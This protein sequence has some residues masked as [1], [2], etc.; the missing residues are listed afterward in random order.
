MTPDTVLE[1]H[2]ASVNIQIPL[3]EHNKYKSLNSLITCLLLL[4]KLNFKAF[5]YEMVLEKH[6]QNWRETEFFL[7]RLG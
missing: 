1:F 6:L 3:N 7:L 2:F 4:Y 5:W